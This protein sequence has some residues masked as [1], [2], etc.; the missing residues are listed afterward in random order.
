M[1]DLGYAIA[2]FIVAILL[3]VT[4]HEFG[5]FWV[6]RKLGVKVLRF[7]IGF[8][9]P[10]FSWY[11]RSGDTEY[12][13]AAL[14]LGGYVKM[15]DEREEEVDPGERH[16]AFNTQP[17]WKRS[18]IVVGGPLANFLFAIL[19]YWGILLMGESGLRPEVGS[20]APGSIAEAAAFQPG[21]LVQGVDGRETASWSR[22]WYA[23]LSASQDGEDVDVAVRTADGR[24]VVRILPGVELKALDPGRGFL[25]AIGLDSVSPPIPPL[26]AEVVDGEPAQRAGLLPGDRVLAID[27]RPIE[28]W[29]ELVEAVRSHPDAPMSL[30]VSRD[31]SE[32]ELALTP[33]VVDV[34]GTRIGRIGAGPFIPEGLYDSYRVRLQYGPVEA[35]GEAVQR[36][37]DL[38]MLTLRIVGRMLVG[39]AS[40]ENLSSPIGIADAAGRT[41]SVGVAP[42]IEFLALL[43]VSLG[44]L[45][46]LPIPVLDGGHLLYFAIEAVRRRPLSEELQAQG[47]RIGIALI[48]SLMTLAFYVDIARLLG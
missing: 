42:Y 13:I 3:L 6:A 40:V 19:V 17:L 8:G 22:F 21:D 28:D 44:L 12:A 36:V 10:L 41:A 38:S 5:H 25:A 31:G 18:A 20:V 14:P 4:V 27:G 30:R 9:R 47:Q 15:L 2:A 33:A 37:G 16:L 39:T 48:I 35:L 45:N 34:E 32:L 43:S 26:I 29:S 23:L 46:L 1:L 24:E 7:S 11:G